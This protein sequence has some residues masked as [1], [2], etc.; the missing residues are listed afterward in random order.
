MTQ[1]YTHLL[2]GEEEAQRTIVFSGGTS[3]II[4]RLSGKL[5]R[6]TARDPINAKLDNVGVAFF[7]PQIHPET[8]KR[9]YSDVRDGRAEQIARRAAHVYFYEFSPHS[10]GSVTADEVIEDGL[11]GK[12]LVVWMSSDT[13]EPPGLGSDRRKRVFESLNPIVEA[14]LKEYKKSGDRSRKQV[15]D[16]LKHCANVHFVKTE[17]EAST[18]LFRILEELKLLPESSNV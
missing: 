3:N 4:D 11:S 7:E 17:E 1:K 12:P 6:N 5:V 15:R 8:H 2:Q 14:H 18:I 10:L 9:E 16:R 13:F